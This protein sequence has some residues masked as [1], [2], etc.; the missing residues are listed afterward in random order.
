MYFSYEQSDYEAALEQIWDIMPEKYKNLLITLYNEPHH[1]STATNISQ[2]SG[3]FDHRGFN[4]LCRIYGPM[5]LTTL[6]K[7]L[8]PRASSSPGYWRI[9]ATFDEKNLK[10]E[11]IIVMRPG[12]VKALEELNLVSTTLVPSTVSIDC[13]EFLAGLTYKED[14]RKQPAV[15]HKTNPPFTI[16]EVRQMV[17]DTKKL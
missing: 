1:T 8:E 9:W 17:Q 12:L 14:K 4:N 3:F 5:F 15:I 11:W 10:G 13:N 16:E 7:R 6:N 2:L